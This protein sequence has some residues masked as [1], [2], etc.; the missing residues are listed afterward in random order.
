MWCV[1]RQRP[2]TCTL[3]LPAPQFRLIANDAWRRVKTY[4]AALEMCSCDAYWTRVC[5]LLCEMTCRH[6][7]DWSMRRMC[8]YVESTLTHIAR[9]IG[10]LHDWWMDDAV[11][12]DEFSCPR[13]HNFHPSP[14]P[15]PAQSHLH[16]RPS[17]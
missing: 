7:L 3:G 5:R 11:I 17:P 10:P 13:K 6:W 12:R 14:L 1:K 2:R 9:P 8:D 15:T 4:H 16:P